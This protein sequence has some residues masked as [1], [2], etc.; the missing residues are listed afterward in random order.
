VE[1]VAAGVIFSRPSVEQF[2]GIQIIGVK[3]SLAVTSELCE[4]Y[5]LIAMNTNAFLIYALYF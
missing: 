5:H 1:V 3:I 4:F 2:V